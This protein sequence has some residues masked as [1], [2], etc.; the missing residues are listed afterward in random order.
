MAIVVDDWNRQQIVVQ[1]NSDLGAAWTQPDDAGKDTRAA[2]SGGAMSMQ[3]WTIAVVSA[4]SGAVSQVPNSSVPP[5][6]QSSDR[7]CT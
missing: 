5:R 3:R 7:G 4:G 6:M 2:A 1:F